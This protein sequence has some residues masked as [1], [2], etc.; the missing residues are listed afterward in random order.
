MSD[1]GIVISYYS[2]AITAARTQVKKFEFELCSVAIG[3]Q[4]IA[5]VSALKQLKIA[6]NANCNFKNEL[7]NTLGNE[8]S[9]NVSQQYALQS[10]VRA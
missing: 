7:I 2:R 1:T 5:R 4:T 9:K 10:A 6:K 8:T 3:T